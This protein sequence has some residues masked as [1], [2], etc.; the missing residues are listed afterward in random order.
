[1]TKLELFPPLAEQQVNCMMAKLKLS[2]L[3]FVFLLTICF[4]SIITYKIRFLLSLPWLGEFSLDQEQCCYF[5]YA[6]VKYWQIW[7]SSKLTQYISNWFKTRKGKICKREDGP[8]CRSVLKC[9]KIWFRPPRSWNFAF[10]SNMSH[11][12][13][14]KKLKIKTN[15]DW[16]VASCCHRA[17]V[18]KVVPKV[19]QSCLK[20]FPKWYMEVIW[21]LSRVVHGICWMNASNL[22]GRVARMPNIVIED[23]CERV[24]GGLAVVDR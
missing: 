11:I 17:E 10:I 2:V 5:I 13:R 20:V 4:I 24:H 18:P 19:S 14:R 7:S 12:R 22:A 1:M 21:K 9:R 6:S 15:T 8:K 16:K 3:Y 23:Q